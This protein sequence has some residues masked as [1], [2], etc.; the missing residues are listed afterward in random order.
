MEMETDMNTDE[1]R[2]R[3][4]KQKKIMAEQSSENFFFFFLV[5]KSVKFCREVKDGKN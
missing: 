2:R 3:K 4:R 1:L 5:R